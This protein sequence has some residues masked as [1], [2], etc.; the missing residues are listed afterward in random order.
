MN[1]TIVCNRYIED[2]VVAQYVAFYIFSA[3]NL[4]ALWRCSFMQHFNSAIDT[5]NVDFEN[6]DKIVAD[7]KQILKDQYSLEIVQEKQLKLKEI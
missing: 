3:Y 7:V 1:F 5:F 4:N 2:N 6:I